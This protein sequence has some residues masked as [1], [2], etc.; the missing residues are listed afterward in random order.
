MKK[1]RHGFQSPIEFVPLEARLA[2]RQFM[3]GLVPVPP[4]MA[5]TSAEWVLSQLNEFAQWG[6]LNGEGGLTALCRKI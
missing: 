2:R 3:R 4:R 6:I 1:R 5:R